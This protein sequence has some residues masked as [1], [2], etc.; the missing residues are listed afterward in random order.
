VCE[1]PCELIQAFIWLELLESTNHIVLF[2]KN[3]HAE[4]FGLFLKIGI[5]RQLVE[6]APRLSSIGFLRRIQ[7]QIFIHIFLLDL[8]EKPYV[9]EDPKRSTLC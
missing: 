2:V 7:Y 3:L 1:I 5:D 8:M 9:V 4:F 6:C